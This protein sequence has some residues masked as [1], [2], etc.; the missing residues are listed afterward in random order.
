MQNKSYI[1]ADYLAI[2]TPRVSDDYQILILNILFMHF[3]YLN[4]GCRILKI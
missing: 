2:Y 4:T 3:I 1:Y